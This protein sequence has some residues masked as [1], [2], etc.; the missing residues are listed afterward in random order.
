MADGGMVR[1]RIGSSGVDPSQIV[2]WNPAVG[3][4]PTTNPSFIQPGT[5]ATFQLRNSNGVVGVSL[6]SGANADID[7]GRMGTGVVTIG[8]PGNPTFGNSHRMGPSSSDYYEVGTNGSL[9][10]VG[11]SNRMYIDNGGVLQLRN[12]TGLNIYNGNGTD[13][14]W[15]RSTTIDRGDAATPADGAAANSPS[16]G[17]RIYNDPV[18]APALESFDF[19]IQYV[20]LAGAGTADV[21]TTV[22]FVARGIL[23]AQIYHDEGVNKCAFRVPDWDISVDGTPA[24]M[25]DGS[26][27]YDSTG[28]AGNRFMGKHAGAFV[29]LG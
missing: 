3:V 12:A 14:R 8:D 16:Y 15:T 5:G 6:G 20:T 13:V 24:N 29:A 26:I 1:G 21:D 17:L 4:G 25:P 23:G 11:S 7:I 22:N 2:I 10:V 27:I 9:W 19:T 18:G 28:A